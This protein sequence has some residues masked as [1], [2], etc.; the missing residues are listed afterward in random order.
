M[1]AS[2]S[3][4]EVKITVVGSGDA[5]CVGARANQSLWVDAPGCRFLIDCGP[6]TLYRLQQL[7]R[8]PDELDLV[9]FTH[10]HGDHFSG[11]VGLDLD[12]TI[13]RK[14]TRPLWYCGGKTIRRRF[15]ALYRACYPSFYPN[16]QFARL[17]K[18][19]VAGRT[20]TLAPG[21]R[22]TALPMAHAPESLGYRLEIGDKS[23][24]ITGDTAWCEQIVQLTQGAGLLLCECE[25]YQR[26]PGNYHHI[27]YEDV[28]DH[29]ALLGNTRV[30]LMHAGDE[31]L[32]RRHTLELPVI[33][34]GMTI[35]L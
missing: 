4:N 29:T 5:F 6:T 3:T 27:A 23:F 31:V 18:V 32:Q 21:I 16:T 33:E 7:G 26:S 28:R 13:I 14:R 30:M 34:D 17:F 9:L 1:S 15:E 35:L 22:V 20:T 12:L 2:K 8:S 19:L 24:A 10:F 11:V 25:Y